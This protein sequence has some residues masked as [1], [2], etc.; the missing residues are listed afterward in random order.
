MNAPQSLLARAL[1]LCLCA[2]ALS[3]RAAQYEF[4]FLS[5]PDGGVRWIDKAGARTDAAKPTPSADLFAE[6][7]GQDRQL[8]R[9]AQYKVLV[10]NGLSKAGWELTQTIESAGDPTYLFKREVAPLAAAKPAS[11]TATDGTQIPLTFTGG[12]DTDPRDHGRPVILIAAALKVPEDV[13]R[14]TFTHVTPARGQE[15]DEAQVRKNKQALMAGLSPYGVTD[16]R[17]NEVSNYY[18]FAGFKGQ[19]WRNTPA[20]GYATVRNGV[21]TA[22]TL[23]NPGAGY[24]SAPKV[25]L[26]GMDHLTLQPKLSFSTDLDKNGSLQ[27][28]P[29]P[30]K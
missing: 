22:I 15:P 9:S 25:S 10:L 16:E 2:S 27:E 23:T 21:V 19:T 12:H 1:I 17:L 26:P 18:R 3:A 28:I 24:S 7:S 29:L 30:S 5:F 11:A 13:F 6:L 4:A 14:D 20:A 8:A